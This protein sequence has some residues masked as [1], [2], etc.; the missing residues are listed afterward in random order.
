[1]RFS[2]QPEVSSL[3]LEEP[4]S[5]VPVLSHFSPFTS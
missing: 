2:K 1:M 4:A 3:W 5:L